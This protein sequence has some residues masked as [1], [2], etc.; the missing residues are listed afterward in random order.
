MKSLLLSVVVLVSLSSVA[1]A[2]TYTGVVSE[3]KQFHSGGTAVDLDGAYPNQ[4]MALYVPA[5]ETR[6]TKMPAVGDKVTAKG[7]ITEYKG[8][9]EIKIHSDDQWSWQ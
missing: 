3:V 2:D 4:K 1:L 7:K 5:N 8:R 9:P 6:V